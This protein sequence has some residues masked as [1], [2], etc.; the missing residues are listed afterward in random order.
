MDHERHNE[1]FEGDIKLNHITNASVV[2]G[3]AFA[4]SGQTLSLHIDPSY[5]ASGS[6]VVYAI[7]DTQS[8]AVQSVT[9]DDVCAQN[10]LQPRLIKLVAERYGKPLEQVA[11]RWRPFRTWVGVLIRASA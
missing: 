10:D 7:P 11:E 4:R 3:A 2:P 9:I 1:A 6:S 8:V 5:F